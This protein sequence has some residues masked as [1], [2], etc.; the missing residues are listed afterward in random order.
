MELRLLRST[1]IIVILLYSLSGWAQPTVCDVEN[2]AMTSTCVEACLICDID[3]FTGRHES[4][5]PGTL[6]DDFCTLIVHNAQWI[7][8]QAASTDLTIRLSV[9][10][11]DLN[12]GLEMGI[13]A[14]NNC[15][16]F[17][18]ISECRGRATPVAPGNSF[19]FTNNEPLI[20]GQY[21]YLA[22]DGNRGDNC[23][24][25]LE[26]L[27]GST[28][29]QPLGS[30]PPIDGFTSICPGVNYAYSIEPSEG[31]ILFDWE[32]NGELL[33]T[34]DVPS[35]D[36]MIEDEGVYNLC[37]TGKNICDAAVSSC[38]VINVDNIEPTII[39]DQFCAEECFE[40]DGREFCETGSYDYTL[41]AVNGCD[42]VILLQLTKLA[43]PINNLELNICELD[44]VNIGGE[45]F[46]STGFFTL[47][48]KDENECD[49]IINLDLNVIIC[50]I[51]SSFLASQPSC[52]G[53]HNG[54]IEFFID[55]G[56][57]PFTYTWQH[58][59]NG[60]TGAGSI[61]NLGE[62]ITIQS[63]PSG[64]VIV[65]IND[66]FD[67]SEVIIATITD[68]DPLSIM[69]EVSDF[70]EFSISCPDAGDGSISVEPSGGTEPYSYLW[71]QNSETPLIENL[72]SGSYTVVVVDGNGCVVQETF[73][74]A[75][76]LPLRAD[77]NYIDPLCS[78]INSGTI[79]IEN[80][81]GGIP[82]YSLQLDGSPTSISPII[83]GLS[84]GEYAL[85]IIDQNGCTLISSDTIFPIA[86]P[87]I[88]GETFYE[89]SLGNQLQLS[90]T[91]DNPGPYQVAWNTMEVLDCNSCLSPNLT[92]L[93]SSIL[94]LLVTSEDGC[95][96]TLSIQVEVEKP[97]V[98]HTPNVFSPNGDG[99]NDYF[100]IIGSLEIESY[101]LNV[102]DRW[103]NHVFQATGLNS[104]EITTNGWDGTY[105]NSKAATGVY[106][107]VAEISFID[108]YKGTFSGEVAVIK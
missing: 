63:L 78:D 36:L 37:V 91:V 32:L 75:P 38:V 107:W 69:G 87:V 73:H 89:V 33:S 12:F 49:S 50:N 35:I 20:I 4:D 3:G 1:I 26:V 71:S 43:Q 62:A 46:S 85:E 15:G 27:E 66:D 81:S 74:L 10:N 96:D 94:E 54:T 8:F 52:F 77:I 67:N 34:S 68:P 40:I 103:G 83:S 51:E 47:N 42:S 105:D 13:Y 100:G 5:V 59:D 21:Y 82:G 102:Y 104:Q 60:I 90:A 106:V 2:P 58:L 24:W 56:T 53:D 84:P 19:D 17:N 9:S 45:A 93:N 95:I 29:I 98:F 41:N 55:N 18:L 48:L 16:N 65:E 14:G 28:E 64:T 30:T 61:E 101:D 39:I 99:L 44:T 92:P 97:R 76:P 57:P 31:M 6:P 11:C 25:T 86:I 23:N 80:I 22:M 108:G 88:M 7:A 79:T 70:N 72:D